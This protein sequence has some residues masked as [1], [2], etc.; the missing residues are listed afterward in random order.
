M[1]GV[2]FWRLG[3][4]ESLIEEP[5]APAVACLSYAALCEW[6]VGEIVAC[7]RN[8]GRSGLSGE[9]AK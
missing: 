8:N 4:I 6:Q 3:E 5:V 1:R 7:H 2:Q 9:G